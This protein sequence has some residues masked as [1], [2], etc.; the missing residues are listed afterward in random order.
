MRNFIKTALIIG[1]LGTSCVDS[2]YD[3]RS[4]STDNIALG[5]E[6][7]APFGTMNWTLGHLFGNIEL[8]EKKQI[9]IPFY[10]EIVHKFDIDLQ[11]DSDLVDKLIEGG[12]LYIES[13]ISNIVPTDTKMSLTFANEGYEESFSVAIVDKQFI[14][15]AS[16]TQPVISSFSK[17][18]TADEFQKIMECNKLYFTISPTADEQSFVVNQEVLK[19]SLQLTF[20]L[21][22]KGGINL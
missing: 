6:L 5:G 3:L 16:P 8:T 14:A 2:Q 17:L 15:S 19:Q 12:E 21:L 1:V 22:K 4:V 13:K 11:M 7:K 18:V 9:T 10:N 20:T